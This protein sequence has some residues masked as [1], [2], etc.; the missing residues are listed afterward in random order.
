MNNHLS[1]LLLKNIFLIKVLLNFWQDLLRKADT[2][3]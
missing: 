2:K 3:N 1:L